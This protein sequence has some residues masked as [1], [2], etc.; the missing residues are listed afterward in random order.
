MAEGKK[1]H[2]IKARLT[3]TEYRQLLAVEK[4][5]GLNHTDLIRTKV[6]GG[7]KQPVNTT[8]IF[9]RLDALGAELAR[10]GNNINQLARHANTLRLRG[11]LSEP[12]VAEFI[13]QFRQYARIR[14][15]TEQ[16]LRALIRLIR[17]NR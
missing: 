14:S 5:L 4:T 10:A 3:D 6:L 9:Q 16:A 7:T 13:I 15:N 12:V 11:E 2:V 17:D 1:E 8:A